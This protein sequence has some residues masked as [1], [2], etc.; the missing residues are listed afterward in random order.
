MSKAKE[1]LFWGAITVLPF[2]AGLLVAAC[3]EEADG[4]VAE[5]Q[6]GIKAYLQPSWGVVCFRIDGDHGDS[7]S[8]V[9]Q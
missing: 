3:A 9:K 5:N 6:G 2:A 8:C 7:L 1:I 4:A